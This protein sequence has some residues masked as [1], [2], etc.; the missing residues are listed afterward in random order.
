MQ[1]VPVIHDSWPAEPELIYGP[2]FSNRKEAQRWIDTERKLLT[3]HFPFLSS[4][5]LS[6]A[7]LE[8]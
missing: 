5:Y 8:R 2:S 1:Y 4:R 7:V 3:K 6:F